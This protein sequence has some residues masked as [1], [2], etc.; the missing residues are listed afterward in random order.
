MN[1]DAHR[2]AAEDLEHSI[3]DLGDPATRPYNGRALIE[4]YWGAAFEWLAYGCGRKLGKHK[5]KHDGLA[6]FLRDVS[7]SGMADRWA[8]MEGVRQGG[9][10]GH[11]VAAADVEQARQLWQDIRTWALS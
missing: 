1:T 2:A 11:H 9:F 6:R 8:A 10:Y 7:E 3:A 5:E 4:L